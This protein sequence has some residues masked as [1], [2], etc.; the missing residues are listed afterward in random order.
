MQC[1]EI[2]KST[3]CAI[4]IWKRRE[5][6]NKAVMISDNPR[7]AKRCHVTVCVMTGLVCVIN[8]N[9]FFCPACSHVHSIDIITLCIKSPNCFFS[10]QLLTLCKCGIDMMVPVECTKW[11][12]S[13]WY[14]TLYHSCVHWAS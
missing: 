1:F 11:T 3:V 6:I 13:T 5:K 9:N 2:A 4:N 8:Q 14:C 7:F 12:T 10:G